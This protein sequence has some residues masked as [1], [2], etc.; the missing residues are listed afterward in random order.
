MA[1]DIR[2]LPLNS[3]DIWGHPMEMGTDFFTS[4]TTKF[5]LV[6][7]FVLTNFSVRTVK[8][9]G[10]PVKVFKVFQI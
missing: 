6:N 5:N 8:G 2:K 7:D 4:A 9:K 3:N 1:K 10:V